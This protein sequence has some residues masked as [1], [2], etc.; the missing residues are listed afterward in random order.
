MTKQNETCDRAWE[1][2]ALREG[3]LGAKDAESFERHARAC[4]VCTSAAARAD[5]LRDLARALPD[6][7]PS[8]LSV[9]RVRS[10]VLH[11][12]A[13]RTE[14][15]SSRPLAAPAV[16]VGLVLAATTAAFFVARGGE[17]VTSAARLAVHAPMREGITEV[18]YAARVTNDDGAKWAQSRRGSTERVELESGTLTIRVRHQEVGERFLVD[19]PDGELEVRGTTFEVTARDGVTERVH[20]DEGK[21]SLRVVGRAELLLGAGA[22]WTHA[23]APFASATA[24]TPLPASASASAATPS[25]SSSSSPA[26]TATSMTSAPSMGGA[27][28]SAFADAV[29]LLQSGRYEAAADAFHAFVGAHASASQAEDASYLEAVALARA[30]RVD[31]AGLAAERHLA[32]FP[33]SFHAKEAAILVARAARDRGDCTK[34][35]AVLAPWL[36][37]PQPDHD[38]LAAIR[39]CR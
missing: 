20:V 15:P 29:A 10:R 8:D 34:A 28:E 16:G 1:I 6:S 39:T 36:A 19:L 17:H 22:T 2:D 13:T 3:K 14:R 27:E 7:A 33:R 5:R 26:T 30:G 35:R 21:V 11:A 23:D 25:A 18:Q 4:E 32:S 24:S 12:V 9:R 31:A 38:A 37:G